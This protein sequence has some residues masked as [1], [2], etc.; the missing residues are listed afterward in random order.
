M[1]AGND[2]SD[3]RAQA[4]QILT[5]IR[6]EK[7]DAITPP[8]FRTAI[9]LPALVEQALAELHGP[10]RPLDV[11]DAEA[12]ERQRPHHEHP[13]QGPRHRADRVRPPRCAQRVPATHGR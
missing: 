6:A 2:P 10:F 8:R 3:L 11:V 4:D 9:T 1:P 7:L 12:G 13:G 5:Q